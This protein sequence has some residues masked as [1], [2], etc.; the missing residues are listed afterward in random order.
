LVFLR[1]ISFIE[2]AVRVGGPASLVGAFWI[3]ALA[4]FVAEII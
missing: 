3:A 2:L 1:I 4:F